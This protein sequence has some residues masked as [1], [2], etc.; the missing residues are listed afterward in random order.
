MRKVRN[1][2]MIFKDLL[3]EQV[4][5]HVYTANVV[6]EPWRI[7]GLELH[8]GTK[9]VALML[10]AREAEELGNALLEGAKELVG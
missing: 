10:T 1:M 4:R 3:D 6:H 5:V 8:H 7:V 9:D 2:D